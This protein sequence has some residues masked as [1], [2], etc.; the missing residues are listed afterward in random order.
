MPSASS[1]RRRSASVRGLIP[2]HECSSWEKRRGPSERSWTRSAVHLAPMISAEAATA[3]VPA[4]WTGSIVRVA[5]VAMPELYVQVQR[6]S[7]IPGGWVVNPAARDHRRHDLDALEVAVERIPV[8]DDEVGGAAGEERPA[9]PFVVR[10]PAGRDAGGVQRLV[11]RQPLVLAPV[12]LHRRDDTGPGVELLDRR[13]R[14]VREQRARMEKRPVRVDAVEL[15]RPEA[16]RQLFVRGRVRE[17]HRRRHTDLSEERHILRCQALRML[18]PLPQSARMPHVAR[19][20]ERIERL[21]VRAVADRMDA[22][23]PTCLSARADDLRELLAARDADAAPVE[24]P[25]RLRPERSVHEHLQVAD[26]QER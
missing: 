22:D 21:T 18:D 25:R 7:G 24:H 9:R 23:G 2:W 15:V 20:L 12:A 26:A 8:E 5:G 4:S 16:L 3:Q 14:A 10:E 19:R 17:L 6:Y 13:V 11:E 1:A